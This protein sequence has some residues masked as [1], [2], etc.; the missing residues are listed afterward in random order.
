MVIIW[1]HGFSLDLILMTMLKSLGRRR[2]A[3]VFSKGKGRSRTRSQQQKQQCLEPVVYNHL[4]SV[5]ERILKQGR[6]EIASSGTV[7][8]IFTGKIHILSTIKTLK[9]MRAMLSDERVIAFY[10]DNESVVISQKFPTESVQQQRLLDEVCRIRIADELLQ[11][12]TTAMAR[13]VDDRI[14]FSCCLLAALASACGSLT[15]AGPNGE[16]RP[17]S[18]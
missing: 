7:T 6:A 3:S 10:C 11:E 5:A 9:R 18:L 8:I 13:C 4:S 1:R 12:T 17:C 14:G 16:A 2:E 15:R